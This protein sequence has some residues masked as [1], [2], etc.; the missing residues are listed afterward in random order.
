MGLSS[1]E[2]KI[3]AAGGRCRI[4]NDAGQFLAYGKDRQIQFVDDKD[5]A[6]VY[7]YV[8]DNVPGQLEQVRQMYSAKWYAVPA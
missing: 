7:D 1:E 4:V 3:M 5:R 8:R 6:F 2:V